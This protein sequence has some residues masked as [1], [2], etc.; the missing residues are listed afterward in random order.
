MTR[1]LQRMLDF[2]DIQA[3]SD[4]DFEDLE[5]D[6]ELIKKHQKRMIEK[7]E[8]DNIKCLIELRD[9]EDE[10]QT[11]DILFDTQYRVIK[12]MLN[13]YQQDESLSG[14]SRYG[15]MYLGEALA[16]LREYTS[17]TGRM[18]SRISRI[19][20]DVSQPKTPP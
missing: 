20:R 14:A 8:R 9:M 13:I 7:A 1:N 6:I 5:A 17:Q 12:D 19:R 10:L 15:R 4:D 18:L 2:M 3:Y 11:L 16:R